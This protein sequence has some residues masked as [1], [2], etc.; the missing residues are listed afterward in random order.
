MT[1]VVCGSISCDA[2]DGIRNHAISSFQLGLVLTAKSCSSCLEEGIDKNPFILA[3]QIAM[4]KC[5]CISPLRY[6]LYNR[7]IKIDRAAAPQQ[8]LRVA[9]DD[10][11]D[12]GGYATVM[13]SRYAARPAALATHCE[14]HRERAQEQVSR[15]TG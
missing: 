1:R 2:Y 8:S 7:Y 13:A 15:I 5:V 6:T 14:C 4:K 9:F 10:S 12:N 11:A 3:E